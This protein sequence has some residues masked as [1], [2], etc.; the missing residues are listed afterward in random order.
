MKSR[1]LDIAG[2]RVSGTPP[3]TPATALE[4]SLLRCDL[5]DQV[6]RRAL[7]VMLAR[8]HEMLPSLETC[9]TQ[10]LAP[11]FANM[12]TV[13]DATSAGLTATVPASG[14]SPLALGWA[15]RRWHSNGTLAA[16]IRMSAYF[17]SDGRLFWDFGVAGRHAPP[18][19][20][21][22]RGIL[23]A[24]AMAPSYRARIDLTPSHEKAAWLALRL[25]GRPTDVH[26]YRAALR[27]GLWNEVRHVPLDFEPDR[28]MR[29]A[30]PRIHETASSPIA[31]SWA[32]VVEPAG[33]AHR[34]VSGDY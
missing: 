7:A 11:A 16:K 20:S 34:G 1:L 8:W 17:D 26:G 33:A 27:Q 4:R 29:D 6:I 23:A 15:E 32:P 22:R 18:I 10:V 19:A 14:R 9:C 25:G 24:A 5:T 2:S 13:P 31:A 12:P 3:E 28:A 21:L 30:P